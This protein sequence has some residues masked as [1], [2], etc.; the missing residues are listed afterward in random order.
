MR[1]L[2]RSTQK[3]AGIYCDDNKIVTVRQLMF[4][5]FLYCVIEYIS[6]LTLH[7][8]FLLK[9]VIKVLITNYVFGIKYQL[10]LKELFC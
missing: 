5:L 9:I 4:L 8:V 6:C 1:N 3:N 7:F 2:F 10:F